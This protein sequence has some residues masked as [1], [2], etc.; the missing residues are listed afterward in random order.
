MAAV[1]YVA[2][3]ATGETLAATAAITPSMSRRCAPPCSNATPGC[4]ST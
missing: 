2:M 1:Q 3:V 4:A